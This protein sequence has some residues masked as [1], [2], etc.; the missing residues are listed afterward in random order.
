MALSRYSVRDFSEE[1]VAPKIID[2][3]VV[4]A[5]KSPSVCNRQGTRVHAV[6][7]RELICEIM[8]LHG[9]TRGFTEQIDTLLVVT[10][11]LEI[12]FGVGE[13][14]QAYVDAGIF[15]M[16][17]LY[18]LHYQGVG[19]CSLHWCVTPSKD[20]E[21]RQM[22]GVP[23]EEVIVMLIAVGSLPEKFKV[24]HS[25]RRPSVDILTWHSK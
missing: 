7:R 25:Q 12:F 1:P 21:L 5:Q 11:D 24:A 6:K 20:R 17:L 23:D 14:N 8:E 18:G 19:S 4:W 9:G 2:Q 13:R 3:A 15:S 10:G 16:S 22:V